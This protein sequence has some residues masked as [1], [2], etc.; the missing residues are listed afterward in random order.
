MQVVV[1][2]QFPFSK[3]AECKKIVKK[4]LQ[5]KKI[6]KKLFRTKKLIPITRSVFESDLNRKSKQAKCNHRPGAAN[7]L[8]RPASRRINC[9]I[10]F[11]SAAA[12]SEND[13]FK[14]VLMPTIVAGQ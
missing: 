11:I 2:V 13:N 4:L 6:V 3:T 7:C 10:V 1:S 8:A 9:V 12:L 14:I 5:R